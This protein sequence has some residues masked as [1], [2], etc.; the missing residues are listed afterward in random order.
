MLKGTECS[1]D[2]LHDQ[3]RQL[4]AAAKGQDANKIIMNLQEIVPEY[5][6]ANPDDQRSVGLNDDTEGQIGPADR[7]SQV[8]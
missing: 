1:L 8:G 3:I 4:A 6:T 2:I 7:L 5:A